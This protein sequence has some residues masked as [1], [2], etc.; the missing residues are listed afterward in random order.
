MRQKSQRIDVQTLFH[1]SLAA[2][3]GWAKCGLSCGPQPDTRIAR[4]TGAKASV[5]TAIG[6]FLNPMSTKL[7]LSLTH[8]E[9]DIARFLDGARS[10][11]REDLMG[12]STGI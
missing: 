12:S 11:L 7:Y 6:I 5:S 8:P 3:C 4:V 9:A 10:A 2:R 1:P